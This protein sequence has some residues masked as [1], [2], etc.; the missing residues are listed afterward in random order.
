MWQ[1]RNQGNQACA[2]ERRKVGKK[3]GEGRCVVVKV[4]DRHVQNVC[5]HVCACPRWGRKNKTDLRMSH[6]WL[7]A[8][9]RVGHG[10]EGRLVGM[11]R[12]GH[13]WDRHTG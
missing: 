9:R 7:L 2:C 5:R 10:R 8:G 13:G 12:H 6:I 4:R 11:G 3:A 1:A